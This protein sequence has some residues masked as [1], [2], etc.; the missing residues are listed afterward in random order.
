MVWK[1]NIMDN[2]RNINQDEVIKTLMVGVQELPGCKMIPNGYGG[3]FLQSTI[4]CPIHPDDEARALLWVI[5][6]NI[7]FASTAPIERLPAKVSIWG[8]LTKWLFG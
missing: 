1:D 5:E 3:F 4:P 7:K 8:K 6:N 2:N